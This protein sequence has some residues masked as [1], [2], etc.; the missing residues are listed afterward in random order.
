MIDK[1]KGVYLPSDI[2]IR[3]TCKRTM[4]TAY[5]GLKIGGW[6]LLIDPTFS[7]TLHY[8]CRIVLLFQNLVAAH[9]GLQASKK[10]YFKEL[11]INREI[12]A[13]FFFQIN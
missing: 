2:K 13:S 3:L 6:S 12:L 7:T 1:F 10:L 11:Q 5:I 9:N 8:L 4:H